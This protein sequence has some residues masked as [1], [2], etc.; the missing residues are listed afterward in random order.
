MSLMHMHMYMSLRKMYTSLN[1][2]LVNDLHMTI[3]YVKVVMIS[4]SALVKL[5]F[6]WEN[7]MKFNVYFLFMTKDWAIVYRNLSIYEA[8]VSSIK[9]NDRKSR[10]KNCF[11]KKMSGTK[12]K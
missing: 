10:A 12:N 2:F 11:Q 8:F 3:T 1:R 9:T 7:S 5:Q 4:C 6:V